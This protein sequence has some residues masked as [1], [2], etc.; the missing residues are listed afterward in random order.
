MS[1]PEVERECQVLASRL[2]KRFGKSEIRRFRFVSIPRGGPIVLGLLSYALQLERKQLEAGP[3]GSDQPLVIVDDCALTGIR[4]HQFLSRYRRRQLVFAP[5]F[6]PPDLRRSIEAEEPE[7]LACLSAQDL[8]DYAPEEMGDGYSKWKE[9]WRGRLKGHRYWIGL[10]PHL[11]FPWSETDRLLWN[12]VKERAETAWHVVP[13]E[14]CLE[15]RVPSAVRIRVQVPVPAVGPL[16][17]PDHVF[18]CDQ[19]GQIVVG[20]VRTGKAIGLT[21]AGSQMW[22]SLVEQGTCEAA[23]EVL[24][25]HFEVE[26]DKL[27]DDLSA[28]VRDLLERGLLEDARV[29][30]KRQEAPTPRHQ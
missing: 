2:T 27:K 7:V 3:D 21:G 18:Y 15:N 25:R 16:K 14:L 5:L 9:R 24:L 6:S 30:R 17:P 4:F 8:H 12:P 28:F 26:A 22:R 19:E 23:S 13:P 10:V 29:D 11:C 1:Y 20:E